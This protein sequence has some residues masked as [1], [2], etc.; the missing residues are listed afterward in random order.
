MTSADDD[1]DEEEE[2]EEEEDD[3]DEEDDEASNSKLEE[4]EL[5]IRKRSLTEVHLRLRACCRTSG[6][7]IS[8]S[9][10]TSSTNVTPI[11]SLVTDWTLLGTG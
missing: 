6:P 8:F 4:M 11:A 7:N 9:G 1:D 5:A 2:E 3:D 10:T